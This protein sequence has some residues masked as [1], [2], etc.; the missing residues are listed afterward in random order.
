[1][2]RY[3]PSETLI[4]NT[5]NNSNQL[6][7][8]ADITALDDGGFVVTW[9]ND[10]QSG[11]NE[12]YGQ[13]FNA[14]G[15][16]NGDSFQINTNTAGA[17][18]ESAITTL[19]DGGFVVTWLSTAGSTG[20]FAQRYFE[21]G[22]KNG[23]EFQI[24][25][26][27]DGQEES[28]AIAAL[29]DGGFVITWDT[30]ASL[31]DDIPS[32]GKYI[33]GKRYN[34]DGSANGDEFQIS[35]DPAFA[36]GSSAITALKSGGFVVTWTGTFEDDLFEIVGKRYNADG[37]E[38]GEEFRINTYTNDQQTNPELTELSDGGLIVTWSSFSQDEAG[39]YGIFAQRYNADGSASG[40]EFQVNTTTT[41]DQTYSSVIAFDDGS[42][43][44]IW[45]SETEGVSQS[46]IIGQRF[47][48][49]GTA[50]GDEFFIGEAISGFRAQSAITTLEDGSFAVTW[51]GSGDGADIFLK[52]FQRVQE[53]LEFTAEDFISYTNQD[54][55]VESFEVIDNTEIHIAGNTWKAIDFDYTVTE[56][57][58]VTF[59]Y[60]TVVEGEIH[61]L[62]F[63]EDGLN[64][65]ASS[66]V[67]QGLDL[68][69]MDGLQAYGSPALYT[70]TTDTF[71]SITVKLSDY[72]DIG[73]EID[74]LVF[75]NDDDANAAG[76]SV[77]KDI[78]VFE[79]QPV[80]EP[81]PEG[82]PLIGS[83]E[84]QVN[85][86]TNGPFTINREYQ[87]EP[88]ITTLAD[89]SFIVTWSNFATSESTA[90]TGLIAQRFNAD[91]SKSGEEF[92]IQNLTNSPTINPQLAALED[93]GFVV[94]W[95]APM[96]DPDLGDI[97]GQRYNA[98]G[99]I[100][101]DAFQIHNDT[102]W[103]TGNQ[104]I[105]A[106]EDGGFII[107]WNRFVSEIEDTGFQSHEIFGQK[108]DANGMKNGE[109]FQMNST[110]QQ[111]FDIQ[112]EPDITA[113]QDNGFI[114]T[115]E[116]A[117][118]DAVS[119]VSR[120]LAQGPDDYGIHGQLFHS[121]GTRN[122]SVFQINATTLD[123]QHS[124]KIA[125]LEGGGFVVTWES[126]EQKLSNGS[127]DIFAQRYNSDG[128]VNGEEF[129]VVSDISTYDLEVD[130]N[131]TGL[132]DGGFVITWE[133]SQNGF[134]S[135]TDIYA[136]RY[137]ADGTTNGGEM[138][139]NTY[140]DDIQ[141]QPSITALDDGG[142]A[143]VWTDYSYSVHAGIFAKIFRPSSE[144]LEFAQDD[145]IS[146]TNQDVIVENFEVIDNTEVH[147]A[148]NIWKALD[149]E[150]TV[151][152]NSLV[153][154]DYKTV[155]EG[156]IHGLIFLEDGLDPN[157]SGIVHQGLDLIRMDGLQSYGGPSALYTEAADTFQTITVNL[158]DYYDV[159]TDISH[160]VF[161]NDDDANAAG[162]SVYKDIKVYEE[163]GIYGDAADNILSGTSEADYL[164][165]DAGADTFLF[166]ASSFD[167]VDVIGD[168]DIS[169]SDALDI[170]D[171]LIGYDA[172]TDAISDFVQITNNGADSTLSIDI[173]GG[174]DNY[175]PI[176]LLSNATGLSDEDALETAGNLITV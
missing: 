108:F 54:V 117:A 60:K 119:G 19:I 176:A 101:G 156:E 93:G 166:D 96:G 125:A 1:M 107:A 6:D 113:L 149:F 173:D 95:N 165:G 169:E 129:Q 128:S 104:A 22:T 146:Y 57:S 91:G 114:V 23:T 85:V 84:F 65:N 13:R 151:T 111:F 39:N 12:V 40:E 3:N 161:V 52:T 9:D 170:S 92:Q 174:A 172:I 46:N 68:I 88:D 139:I 61:G 30:N 97:F 75:V 49:D 20:I 70:E 116:G 150:Y 73:T 157:A 79:A 69:R 135:S 134:P 115:W 123:E 167:A 138:L 131:I 8:N 38:N 94:T 140:T 148:G 99:E 66:I 18:Y 132:K 35:L 145:F 55:I 154:F 122:G 147:I 153:T 86:P 29:E 158:S 15:S 133:S 42:F 56:D 27:R 144:F 120:G 112:I 77:F 24:N 127:S 26:T 58:Y 171:V 105:T 76:E 87:A 32:F 25:L 16:K 48:A 72:Y 36:Q 10:G 11:V 109:E 21:D 44:I 110:S 62:I 136:Q 41:N 31:S 67:H 14:D 143:V 51:M 33:L 141:G 126:K 100:S 102:S 155:I 47:N 74:H 71:Q 37:S 164:Y 160:L 7:A 121:N 5:P 4:V 159:G 89:G 63:L 83:E 137:N 2:Q 53:F 152:E 175:I 81:L 130:V 163:N 106:L 82:P 80:F 59:D 124:S 28:P 118:Q 43:A 168:F 50:N 98:D 103:I 78:K 45:E 34:A 142:F 64:P 17:Q 90:D 162:E